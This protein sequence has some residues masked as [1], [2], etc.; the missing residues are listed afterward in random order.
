MYQ[1]FRSLT[2]AIQ[3]ELSKRF[4]SG[5]PTKVFR[6][7]INKLEE[8]LLENRV[9]YSKEVT[10][11]WLSAMEESV[12]RHKF[13]QLRRAVH[14][15]EGLHTTGVVPAGIQYEK[16]TR[17]SRLPRWCQ[18]EVSEYIATYEITHTQK[19]VD[20]TRRCIVNFLTFL[21]RYNCTGKFDWEQLKSYHNE[22]HAKTHNSLHSKLSLV[23]GFVTHLEKKGIAPIESHRVLEDCCFN[24]L[25]LLSELGEEKR[26]GFLQSSSSP[27]LSEQQSK[28][29]ANAH[30]LLS[31]S[32]SS[33]K[34]HRTA[35]KTSMQ[36]L[37][38]FKLFLT[39]NSLPVRMETASL[40]VELGRC[41]WSKAKHRA[42]RRAFECLAVILETGTI[43]IGS[44]HHKREG[45]PPL[46]VMH[47]KLIDLFVNERRRN[48]ISESTIHGDSASVVRMLRF[49]EHAGIAVHDVDVDVL[50]DYVSQDLKQ[51]TQSGRLESM[52][53]IKIFL[54]FLGE[55][56]VVPEALQLILSGSGARVVS[57]VETL[58]QEAMDCFWDYRRKAL[59]SMQLRNVA[60]AMLGLFMGFRG[61]DVRKLRIQDISFHR[62]CITIIQ[63]KTGVKI[64]QPMPIEVA[65]S[66]YRYI[67]EGRPSSSVPNVF[68]THLAHRQ[69]EELRSSVSCSGAC[70]AIFGI[71]SFHIL[72]RTFASRMLCRGTPVPLI[73]SALGQVGIANVDP[74][75]STDTAHM[76]NCALPLEGLAFKGGRL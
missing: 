40:W 33:G 51:S 13:L 70:K 71:R 73:A 15:M 66:L 2:G 48:G 28:R 12:S 64:V 29:Y 21:T 67:T 65:N 6:A 49:F 26:N 32:L 20:E 37:I 14:L 27:A 5:N 47:E 39:A 8:Y 53:N 45:R 31:T 68:V 60:M 54:K 16:N 4:I 46:N 69:G 7:A 62:L 72:R 34:Y 23:R 38:D 35:V 3:V 11:L 61:C 74:Y 55:Q 52:S 44:V 63:R 56:K 76:R 9:E 50:L 19:T 42:M 22:I 24:E 10:A 30:E 59:D 25:V 75:L 18:D 58:P 57:I 43:S 17:L 41:R 1:E 36:F